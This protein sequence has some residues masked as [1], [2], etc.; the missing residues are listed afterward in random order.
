MNQVRDRQLL[1][2]TAF[3]QLEKRVRACTTA[4]ELAFLMVNDTHMMVTYRQAA[5]WRTDKGTIQALSGLVM[6]DKDAPFTVWLQGLFKKRLETAEGQALAPLSAAL[7]PAQ[8]AESWAHHLP[9][10]AFWVPLKRPGGEI[11]GVLLLAREE[12]WGEPERQM[13]EQLSDAY[14]HGWAALTAGT[15]RRTKWLQRPRRLAMGVAAAALLVM[16]LP[17]RQSVLAPAE[18]VARDPVIIRA[19]MQGVVETIHVQPNA[20]VSQ[21]TLL[22]SMDGREL[23]SRL[24]IARQQRAVAEAELRQAQ[25]QAVFDD[26]SRAQ[27]AILQ[28]RREQHMAEVAYIE[29]LLERSRMTAPRDGIAIFDDVGDWEGRPVSLGE[30]IMLVADPKDAELEVQ[31]PVADAINLEPGAEMEFYLNIDPSSPVAASLVRAGY[32]A[33][34]TPDNITAYRLL[35]RFGQADDRLRVGLKGTA[36]IYGD[37]TILFI[38][39]M[40]RPLAAMRIWLNF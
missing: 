19:P 32:R 25:Q 18:V 21:G 6:P 14:A 17:V 16:L 13:L 4:E 20:T 1:A 31:L 24:D 27:L 12:A 39:L 34:T 26:K 10:N 8:E 28:G 11:V 7:L 38:Y 3:L 36:K 22:A 30:R 5:F 37:R 9:A 40:R 15:S 23:T 29:G 35:A 2:L 33:S